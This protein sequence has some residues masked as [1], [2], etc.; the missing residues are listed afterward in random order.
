MPEDFTREINAVTN[1]SFEGSDNNENRAP[2]AASGVNVADLNA[3]VARDLNEMHQVMAM[4]APDASTSEIHKSCTWLTA[5]SK[6]AAN[7]AKLYLMLPSELRTQAIKYDQFEQLFMST[8]NNE[9]SNIL[10]PVKDSAV[11]LFTHLGLDPCNPLNPDEQYTPLAPILFTDPKTMTG[12]GLFK[13]KILTRIACVLHHG[14]GV[15]TGKKCGGPPGR[16]KKLKATTTS[17]GIIAVTLTSINYENDFEFYIELLCKPENKKWALE[18]MELFDKA[19]FS[20][21]QPTEPSNNVSEAPWRWEDNILAQLEGSQPMDSEDPPMV[22]A[23][24]MATAAHI[25]IPPQQHL[26]YTSGASSHHTGD[27]RDNVEHAGLNA[28]LTTSD[29]QVPLTNLSLGLPQSSVSTC[30]NA[31][32]CAVVPAVVNASAKATRKGKK[33]LSLRLK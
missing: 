28:S 18:V 26:Y 6:A 20:I 27:Q 21:K 1:D 25:S 9:H 8:V 30:S 23:I 4:P 5:E 12:S 15:L 3:N 16:G 31:A 22:G 32:V 33:E 14:K 11:Q 19:V 10:K 13:N 7:G 24:N 29:L 17:E 2:P